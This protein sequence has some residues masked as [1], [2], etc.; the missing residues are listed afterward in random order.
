MRQILE[1]GNGRYMETSVS[2]SHWTLIALDADKKHALMRMT[3][4]GNMGSEMYSAAYFLNLIG[5]T[6]RIYGD[7]L[8]GV[9]STYGCPRSINAKNSGEFVKICEGL[10][11]SYGHGGTGITKKNI[12][13][14]IALSSLGFAEEVSALHKEC[15]YIFANYDISKVVHDHS[16]RTKRRMGY[17]DSFSSNEKAVVGFAMFCAMLAALSLLREKEDTAKMEKP[18]NDA[19]RYSDRILQ[20]KQRFLQK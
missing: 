4:G 7:K 1:D 9:V 3:A 10:V 17:D 15:P 11:A 14:A 12:T 6:R 2:N 8:V 19:F 5:N 20:E 18:P 13:A 16:Q